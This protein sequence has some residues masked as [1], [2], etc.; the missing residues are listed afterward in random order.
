MAS[1]P[2]VQTFFIR[3]IVDE[4]SDIQI[5][6]DGVFRTQ[7]V[8]KHNQSSSS[9]QRITQTVTY[10]FQPPYDWVHDINSMAAN[11]RADFLTKNIIGIKVDLSEIGTDKHAF[12]PLGENQ[13][14]KMAKLVRSA[15]SP[16]QVSY[17]LTRKLLNEVH[18]L[19]FV[20][21]RSL[22]PSSN[23][24]FDIAKSSLQRLVTS[25]STSLQKTSLNSK[26]TRDPSSSISMPSC[27]LTY[28]SLL[29]SW[30]DV[31]APSQVYK[32][33]YVACLAFQCS[34]SS[35]VQGPKSKIAMKDT[36]YLLSKCT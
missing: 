28:A 2:V 20:L 23:T 7:C 27:N 32:D 26:H 3:R 34:I 31:F 9:L 13:Q 33:W 29:H 4:L 25:L 10:P 24:C 35:S 15:S 21:F 36:R 5:T 12:L 6:K 22:Q 14:S 19:I 30:L 11:D 16:A 17:Q 18:L 8:V 1:E